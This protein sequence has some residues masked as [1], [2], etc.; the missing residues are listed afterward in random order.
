LFSTTSVFFF[1]PLRLI[2]INL[3]DCEGN[4]VVM[5]VYYMSIPVY[6]LESPTSSDCENIYAFSLLKLAF[7]CCR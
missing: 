3:A 1:S 4:P 5:H 7:N 2:I 6:H